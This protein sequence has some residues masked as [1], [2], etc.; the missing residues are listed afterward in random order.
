[1]GEIREETLG[2][3][4]RLGFAFDVFERGAGEGFWARVYVKASSLGL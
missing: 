1:M 3:C 4:A 2:L